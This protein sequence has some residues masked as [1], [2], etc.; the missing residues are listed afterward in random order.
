MDGLADREGNR[1][2][3]TPQLQEDPRLPLSQV[4]PLIAL[5][6]LRVARYSFGA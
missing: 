1:I 4:P 5:C 2:L 6:N 3:K